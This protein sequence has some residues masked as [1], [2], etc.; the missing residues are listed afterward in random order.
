MTFID[1]TPTQD[2]CKHMS[3][4]SFV[5]AIIMASKKYKIAYKKKRSGWT[6]RIFLDVNIQ[7]GL[8]LQLTQKGFFHTIFSAI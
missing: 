3:Y 4:K 1:F 8:M 7:F 2:W 5:E 6:Y